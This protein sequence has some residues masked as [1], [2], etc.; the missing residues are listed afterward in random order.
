MARPATGSILVKDLAEG[1]AFHLR[2]RA[3]GRRERVVL[4]ERRGCDCGCGGGW[5][6]PGAR[7]ELGDILA[8]VRAG[9]YE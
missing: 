8:R 4:H 6:E 1:R 3:R 7:T 5:D 9:V 2:F